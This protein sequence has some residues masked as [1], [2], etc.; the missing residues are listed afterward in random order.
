MDCTPCLA[1]GCEL[2]CAIVPAAGGNLFLTVF[3]TVHRVPALNVDVLL[4]IMARGTARS[5]VVTLSGR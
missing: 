4:A 1:F 2:N 5:A 3:V